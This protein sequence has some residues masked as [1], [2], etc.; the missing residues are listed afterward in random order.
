MCTLTLNTCIPIYI[1]VY[2]Y[3]IYFYMLCR[4]VYRSSFPPPSC[5]LLPVYL[6]FCCTLFTLTSYLI[7]RFSVL[8]KCS[9]PGNITA[10]GGAWTRQTKRLIHYHRYFIGQIKYA[11]VRPESRCQRGVNLYRAVIV[12]SRRVKRSPLG[13]TKASFI[14]LLKSHHSPAVPTRVQVSV[15]GE[16]ATPRRARS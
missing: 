13:V 5:T 6:D 14:G 16:V 4:F 10:G 15:S 9:V 8:A 2:I 3:Y 7:C 11:Q 12:R 1:S